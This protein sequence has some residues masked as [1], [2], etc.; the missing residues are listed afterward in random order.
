VHLLTSPEG[1]FRPGDHRL[2]FFA[3]LD[4]LQE[5]LDVGLPDALAPWH[6]TGADLVPRPDQPDR[7]HQVPWASSDVDLSTA[8]QSPIGKARTNLFVWSAQ[9]TSGELP[10]D[11]GQTYESLCSVNG[12]LLLQ[13]GR[14]DNLARLSPASLCHVDRFVSA[15]TGEERRYPEYLRVYNRLRRLVRTRIIAP[16]VQTF[17][18][19]TAWVNEDV[20]WTAGAVAA[21]AAGITFV[22]PNGTC[23]PLEP[24]SPPA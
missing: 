8:S 23:K 17:P 1:W 21:H 16:S 24:G 22:T 6:L 18:D 9:L 14:L 15:A 10:C 12:F 13:L 11:P 4:E 3:T 7:Y 2:D 19:G 20:R 5:L